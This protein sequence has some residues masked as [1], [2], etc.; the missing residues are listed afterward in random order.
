MARKV[1]LYADA[2]ANEKQTGLAVGM[3][4]MCFAGN[5]KSGDLR[6]SVMAYL[7][8]MTETKKL[9]PS[10]ILALLDW[11]KP[12]KDSGGAY[13]PD[14]MAIS[15]AQTVVAARMKELGQEELL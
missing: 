11:L 9:W 2:K 3:L 6:H 8:D 7:F 4:E 15:E 14:P 10:Q 5:E 12:E 1:E 13:T